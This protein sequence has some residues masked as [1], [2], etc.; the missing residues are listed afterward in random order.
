MST[1]KPFGETTRKD[2]KRR[3]LKLTRF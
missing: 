1:A 3:N 2:E